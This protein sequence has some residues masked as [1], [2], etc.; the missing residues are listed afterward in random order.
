AV[1]V[2]VKVV[3][4]R[5]SDGTID[6]SRIETRSNEQPPFFEF[7]GTVQTLPNTPDLL[8]D[9]M[10]SNRTVHVTSLT[11]IET[12]DGPITVGTVV[13]VKVFVRAD[14]SIDAVKIEP[15]E[16][17]VNAFEFR[18]TITDLPSTPGFIGDWKVEGRTVHVTAATRIQQEEGLV[19]VG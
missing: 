9:W 8:G 12:E 2:F 1:G 7:T 3:G 5:R 17:E 14:G 10:V 11:R 18:G 15:A 6:A 19:A 13:E 4:M 16:M